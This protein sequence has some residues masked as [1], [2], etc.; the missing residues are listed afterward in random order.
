MA[1]TRS[2]G[3]STLTF[4][5]TADTTPAG[6]LPGTKGS[7]GGNWCLPE[8]TTRSTKFTAVACVSS[9]TSFGAGVGVGSSP[10]VAPSTGP[11]SRTM[12]ARMPFC[13]PPGARGAAPGHNIARVGADVNVGA[14]CAAPG[15]RVINGG[16]PPLASRSS[17]S[18][19]DTLLEE[20]VTANRILARE[21]VVDSFGH[22]SARHPERPDRFL[23]SRA[24]APDCIER[25]D[26][27]EYGLEGEAVPARARKSYLAR[28]IP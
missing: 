11:N 16:R 10:T 12:T 6:P 15:T 19:L 28:F 7:S 21:E 23:L 24:R 20:L 25:E 5:P 18:K 2:P 8:M 3:R 4:E 13:S 27:M 14:R 22:I 17:M 26:L 1:S 9:R